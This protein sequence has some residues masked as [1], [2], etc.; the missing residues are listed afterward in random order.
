MDKDLYNRKQ[1][2]LKEHYESIC[3]SCGACCGV[4]DGDCCVNLA[5]DKAGKYFCKVYDKR[6]GKQKTISGKEF[7]CVEIRDVLKFGPV[8]PGCAYLKNKF[9]P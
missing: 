3:V 4:T 2:E 1:E 8:H 9:R 7:S 5:K 6:L